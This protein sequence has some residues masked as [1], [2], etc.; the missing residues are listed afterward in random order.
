MKMLIIAAAAAALLGAPAAL[1]ASTSGGKAPNAKTESQAV[2]DT[3]LPAQCASLSA[4][5]DRAENVHKA[6]K[7]YKEAV[8]LGTEG[9][10]LCSSNKLAGGIEYLGSAI[11]MLGTSSS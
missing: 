10:T 1:A 5:F 8:A 6:S 2:V 9:T 7:N 3:T 11:K 4:Q